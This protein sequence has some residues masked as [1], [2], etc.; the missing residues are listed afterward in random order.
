MGFGNLGRY[1]TDYRRKKIKFIQK[2]FMR[3]F[4][5]IIITIYC[6][7]CVFLPNLEFSCMFEMFLTDAHF[8]TSEL[9]Y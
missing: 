3:A 6:L 8:S 4:D 5:F 2:E 9:A 7:L 1:L